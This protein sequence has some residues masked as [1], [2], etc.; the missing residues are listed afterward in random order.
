MTLPR[1][2]LETRP[3]GPNQVVE[4]DPGVVAVDRERLELP[5]VEGLQVITGDGRV[6]LAQAPSG[7]YDVVVGD[8]FGG[9]AVPWHLTTREAVAEVFRV[10]ASDGLYALNVI[11]HDPLDFARAEIATVAS[12]FDHVMVIT[13]TGHLVGASGGNIVV[14]ASEQPLDGAA[15]SAAL[16]DRDTPMSMVSP[17]EVDEFL[18]TDPLVLTDDYAPVDQLLTPYG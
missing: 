16:L 10:L 5:D 11:D 2:L 17:A 15:I 7:E 1:Y 13:P 18:G 12:L 14:L 4:L 6:A 3:A 8:A 9:V